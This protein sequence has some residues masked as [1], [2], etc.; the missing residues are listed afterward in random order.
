[1]GVARLRALTQP[2]STAGS[3]SGSV[4]MGV[5]RLRALTQ[6]SPNQFCI[7]E[8]SR[9]G[10]CPVEGIDT[11]LFLVCEGTVIQVEMGVARLRALTHSLRIIRIVV[12]VAV[13]V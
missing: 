10:C 1:M 3:A 4:E 12:S 6:L 2:F 13:A 11:C 7:E 5:A 8:L 9:N